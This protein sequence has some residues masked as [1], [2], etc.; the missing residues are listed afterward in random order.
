MREGGD[1]D[2][3]HPLADAPP[4]A[5]PLVAELALEADQALARR[6]VHRAGFGDQREAVQVI[7]I[8]AAFVAKRV[9]IDGDGARLDGGL[10]DATGQDP[11]GDQRLRTPAAHQVVRQPAGA[12]PDYAALDV[13]T[14][15]SALKTLETAVAESIRR[16]EPRIRELIAAGEALT[17]GNDRLTL[18]I[19]AARELLRHD[20][21]AA[22]T[23]L[24]PLHLHRD[25]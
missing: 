6:D 7:E 22:D 2:R 15:E 5:G 9:A 8:K 13:S 19:A 21:D 4:Q 1:R 10:R 17:A 14:T 16:F 25:G 23:L 18:T 3:L 11:G 24:Q 20:V 12:H